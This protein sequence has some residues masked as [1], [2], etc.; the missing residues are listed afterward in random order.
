LPVFSSNAAIF[1]E[2]NQS[3][4]RLNLGGEHATRPI[5]SPMA[6]ITKLPAISCILADANPRRRGLAYSATSF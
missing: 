1:D 6:F 3:L 2:G 4:L 5:N